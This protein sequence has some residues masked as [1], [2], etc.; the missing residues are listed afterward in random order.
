M[1]SNKSI[2][3]FIAI[4]LCFASGNVLAQTA[5][6]D[7]QLADGEAQYGLFCAECHDGALLEAPQRA[8]F[9]FY[10]PGRIIDVLEFGS[11]AT[12]GMALTREQKRN[13]A[14]YLSGEQYDETRTEAVSFSCEATRD[15]NSPL[16]QPVAW[17]GWGGESGNT[18][19]QAS[20]S[21]L[22][23]TNVNQ[24]E[25]KWAFAT[26]DTTRSRSQPVVT[27]EVTFIGSQEGTVYALDNSNGCPSWTF[28]ADA[29]VRGAIYVDTDDEGIPETLLFGDFA[30]SA[31]AVN[32]RTGELNWKKEVHD[33][34]QATI[35][36]S[37]IAHGDTLIVPVSSLEVL[38]AAR[39]G[40][41]C[42]S[43]RGALVALSISTGE[44]LWRTYTT[45]EPRPTILSTAGIQ[46][47]GPSGAP[48]WSSPTID[49]ERN[50]VYAGTGE[51]Y[52]SPANDYSDA[53]LAMDMLTGEIVWAAQLTKDDA[54]NGACSRGTPN[55]PEED[56]PD[57]DIGASPILTRDENGR[58]I[59]LV[60]QKSG[61][62]YALDPANNGALIWEQRAGSGGT[63]GGIHYGMSTNA[64]KV[65]VG[66]S[67]LP[68]NNPYNVGP[69][70]PG[71]HA[72]SLS[73]GEV[74]WRNDLPNKCEESPFLCWQGISAAVSSTA[75]LVFAGGLDGIL[76]AFDTEDGSILWETNTRQSF[77]TR[78]GIEA[79]G[80]SIESDG[81]VIVNGQVFITSGYEKWGEA[82]GNVLLVYSLNGE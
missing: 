53:V 48:I 76:R 79:R 5:Q 27:A 78:N 56:G 20:E 21:I 73:T 36:G 49:V 61:M 32:A 38:L 46:Q 13:I 71:V 6:D 16:T 29:E 15:A 24:L 58:E 7:A 44:E 11:M 67:D 18:R 43:F 17:N 57:Y 4:W 8:A 54:W 80:G 68:T 1:R 9:E 39:V 34:P 19:H 82:P 50:L 40:Y 62:V 41:S 64:E 77:G 2:F 55:C 72:L 51:N 65:F 14:Y 25:L 74:V 75:D 28:S 66:V 26:P 42:C 31:Y 10:S 35:T 59:I 22:N 63:M 69:A 60:G 33:H 52:S 47:Y 3:S 45:E 23:K 81:P 70:H 12:S 37:V 30:G